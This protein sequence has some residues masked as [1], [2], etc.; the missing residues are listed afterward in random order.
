MG[1][2]RW[3]QRSGKPSRDVRCPGEEERQIEF[4]L[5]FRA[6]IGCD[7]E[8]GMERSASICCSRGRESD[9]S[10]VK[11]ID[12]WQDWRLATG[13]WRVEV[14]TCWLPFRGRVSILLMNE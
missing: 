7:A 5:Q 8:G 11:P 4:E 12:Q 3:R 14:L 6:Q 10:A 9:E 1:N 2:A 13:E